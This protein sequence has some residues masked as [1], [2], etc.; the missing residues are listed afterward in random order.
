MKNSVIYPG[1]ISEVQYW[2]RK[3]GVSRAELN[4]AILETGSLKAEEIKKYLRKRK[5]SF[6]F[7]GIKTFI[8]LCI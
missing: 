5:F 8:K 6:S 2:T 1:E 3:F 7:S 4:E